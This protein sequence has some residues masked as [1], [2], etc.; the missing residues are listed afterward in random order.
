MQGTRERGSP[1]SQRALSLYEA[2]IAILNP[3]FGFKCFQ[4]EKYVSLM[5]FVGRLARHGG[6]S[7][8]WFHSDN[9]VQ[10]PMALWDEGLFYKTAL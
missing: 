8:G 6:A 10:G 3:V 1:D 2:T 5:C 9:Y 4:N 7:N